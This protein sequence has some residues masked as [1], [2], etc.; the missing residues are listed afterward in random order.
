MKK[1]ETKIFHFFIGNMRD[2]PFK[3][4][5]C[6]K[7]REFAKMNGNVPVFLASASSGE[8]IESA[9]EQITHEVYKKINKTGNEDNTLISRQKKRFRVV[10]QEE[11][12]KMI[13]KTLKINPR[14]RK[15]FLLMEEGLKRIYL[16]MQATKS[17]KFQILIQ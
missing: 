6:L 17:I 2:N 3:E 16:K 15:N 13:E 9:I 1:P 8:N 11:P 14:K 4:Y 7:A 10:E 12:F 5:K